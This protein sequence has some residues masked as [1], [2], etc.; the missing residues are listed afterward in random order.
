[1][2]DS[3]HGVRRMPRP[4]LYLLFAAVLLPV[5]LLSPRGLTALGVGFH[6]VTGLILVGLG[7]A[8]RK[9]PVRRYA[10]IPAWLGLLGVG[11]LFLA[12]A[13]FKARYRLF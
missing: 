2:P 8:I 10:G 11:A 9:W 4:V 6:A 12:L 13:F 7:I 3:G 1:M 5:A